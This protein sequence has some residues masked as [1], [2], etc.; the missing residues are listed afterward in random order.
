M[1]GTVT[2]TWPIGTDCK[3][4]IRGLKDDTGMGIA[5]A[6]VTGVLKAAN[7]TPVVNADSITFTAKGAGDYEGLVASDA[8]LLDGR[9]FTLEITAIKDDK[10]LFA[11]VARAAA[12]VNL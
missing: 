5:D 1:A 12:Y 9:Q 3:V 7:G 8:E 10:T 6:T 4:T 2:Q 11:K